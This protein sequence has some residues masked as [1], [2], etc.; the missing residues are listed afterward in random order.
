MKRA[1]GTVEIRVGDTPNISASTVVATQDLTGE[2]LTIS[3][4]GATSARYVMLWFTSLP[5]DGGKFR[6][7]VSEVRVT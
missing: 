3:A 4:T 1:G 5:R 2:Q 6:I 7:E